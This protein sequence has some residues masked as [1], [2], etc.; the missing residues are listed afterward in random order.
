MR[1]GRIAAVCLA[2]S[3]FCVQ[4]KAES[5]VL[6]PKAERLVSPDGRFEVRD[7]GR[8]G[9][10]TDFVGSFH[11]LWLTDLK[12]GNARKLCDYMGIAAVAW[13]GN[14]FLVITQYV[15]KK[16]S[17]ALVFATSGAQD[18]FML[19][20]STMIQLL[21]VEMREALRGNDHVFV[22]ASRLENDRFYFRVWGYG[23]HDPNGFGWKCQYEL[24]AGKVNC[25]GAG[26]TTFQ[27]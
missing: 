6:F 22:E 24:R 4:G 10:A 8:P 7:A 11:S 25:G 19:D 21:P 12:N 3:T 1:L 16:T 2:I 13:S 14:D 27:H 23:Q 20:K 9:A 18:P 26:E 5:F 15:G 17:R